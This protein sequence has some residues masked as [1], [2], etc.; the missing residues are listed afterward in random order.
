MAEKAANTG[1]TGFSPGLIG[2]PQLPMIVAEW[3][4]LLPLVL[5]LASYQA[6]YM[7]IGEISLLGRLPISLFPTLGAYSGFARLLERGPN[8]LDYASA[9]GG[10]SHR[11]WDVNFGNAFTVTNGA[12][13]ATIMSSVLE[14]RKPSR[15]R[16]E[17]P[18]QSNQQVKGDEARKVYRPQ[19]LN[20]YQFQKTEGHK[21]TLIQRA[22]GNSKLATAFM[23]LLVAILVGIAIFLGIF[24]TFGSAVIVLLC[25]ISVVVCETTPIRRPAIYLETGETHDACMLVA[26]HENA[27]EWHLCIG[28]LGVV[29]TVL[30]KP[31]IV[32]PQGTRARLAAFWFR[33][34]HIIQLTAMTFVAGQKGW[35]GVCLVILLVIHYIVSWNFHPKKLARRWLEKEGIDVKVESFEFHGRSDLIH[36]IQFLSGTECHRWIDEIMVPHPRRNFSL[37]MLQLPANQTVQFPKEFNAHDRGKM[38]RNVRAARLGASKIKDVLKDAKVVSHFT[39]P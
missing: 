33:C 11:A 27:T 25:A 26:A 30:N 22:P 36:T 35:D 10:S 31:V 2:Y 8:Y 6:D 23:I 18:I 16:I 38:L 28:D 24:G 7:T 20:V 34:A 32:L 15:I 4:A 39:S 1:S 14:K 37:E 3:A 29:D 21:R 19:V 12:T 9:K 17:L 5:H 13:S